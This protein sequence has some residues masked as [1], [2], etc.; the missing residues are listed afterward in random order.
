MH[1][2]FPKAKFRDCI[3]MT[4]K[5]GH[6]SQL[7]IMRKEWIESTKP[8]PREDN[9]EDVEG[10]DALRSMEQGQNGF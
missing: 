7:R 3:A 8:K 4:E 1:D 5:L 9:V 6:L 2:V 10:L